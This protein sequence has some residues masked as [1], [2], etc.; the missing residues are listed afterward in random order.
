MTS[1]VETIS[2]YESY[3]EI[4][5]GHTWNASVSSGAG[6]RS[7]RGEGYEIDYSKVNDERFSKLPK[8]IV[9]KTGT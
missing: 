8:R 1:D 5:K 4:L 9:D 2:L 7:V 3:F 6:V